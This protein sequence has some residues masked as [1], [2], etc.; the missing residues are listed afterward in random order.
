MYLFKFH[1]KKNCKLIGQQRI[2]LQSLSSQKIYQSS[3]RK[4]FQI[5]YKTMLKGFLYFIITILK[6][7]RKSL[8]IF[9]V[10]SIQVYFNLQYFKEICLN[11]IKNKINCNAINICATFSTQP[12]F[13]QVTPHLQKIICVKICLKKLNISMQFEK[14]NT[15]STIVPE[16]YSKFILQIYISIQ[17]FSNIY[18]KLM[19]NISKN[20][21][22]RFQFRLL[23]ITNVVTVDSLQFKIRQFKFYIENSNQRKS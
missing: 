6:F 21:F 16:I 20:R 3:S 18:S 4:L 2:F 9:L 23:S 1:L 15:N 13:Q 22:A 5:L 11:S 14:E 17:K 8:N 12:K 7:Q 10:K 19:T